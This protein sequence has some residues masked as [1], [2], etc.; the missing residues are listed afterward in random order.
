MKRSSD[1]LEFSSPTKLDGHQNWGLIAQLKT[2]YDIK[3]VYHNDYPKGGHRVMEHG[4]HSIMEGLRKWPIR[5]KED[6][7]NIIAL[8]MK[9]GSFS[10]PRMAMCLDF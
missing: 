3:L 10:L 6:N 5:E 8:L 1:T 2:I 7:N 9:E 4:D